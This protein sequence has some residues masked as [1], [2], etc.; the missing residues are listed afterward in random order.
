MNR[1]HGGLAGSHVA[2]L[3]LIVG[4]CLFV[5]LSAG[6]L[7]DTGYEL[8]VNNV[9]EGPEQTITVEDREFTASAVSTYVSGE[10][11]EASVT[12]PPD[13]DARYNLRLYNSDR[14]QEKTSPTRT[15]D[16]D[17]R[18]G[19]DDL[20]PGSYVLGVDDDGFEV[21]HPVVIQG[22]ETFVS[23]DGED[24][25]GGG[26]TVETDQRLETTVDLEAYDDAPPVH[27]VEVVVVDGDGYESAVTA[28]ESGSGT[29][30]ATVDAPA[31]EG[32]YTLGVVV[33]GPDEM[34]GQDEREVIAVA[35]P[36]DVDVEGDQ[37]TATP[38]ESG[39]A[40]GSSGGGTGSSTGDDDAEADD[41]TPT[42]G[43]TP[44]STPVDDGTTS[45]ATT[46]D[47]STAGTGAETTS[48]SDDGPIT[49]DE[50]RPEVAGE[51]QSG[52]GAAVAAVA[53]LAALLARRAA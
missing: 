23:V 21:V 34:A 45:T 14:Q 25:T 4:T 24:V 31:D 35:D 30:T 22:Y 8:T 46:D 9:V 47:G 12:T 43:E 53:L 37:A 44:T 19:T 18:F 3:L 6:A 51:P 36:V 10:S 41:L 28:T 48:A 42:P 2:A 17:E 49:P 1:P 11:I 38:G 20:P 7:A 26:V 5:G 33:R 52:F 13:G 50:Y 39:S 40:G 16:S 27:A 29:Y 32:A 15:E